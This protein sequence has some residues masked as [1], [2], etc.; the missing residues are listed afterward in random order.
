MMIFPC[1][2]TWLESDHLTGHFTQKI[3]Y[4]TYQ[5]KIIDSLCDNLTAFL[6]MIFCALRSVTRRFLRVRWDFEVYI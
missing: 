5:L 6:L 2:A 4:N 3:T 1:R